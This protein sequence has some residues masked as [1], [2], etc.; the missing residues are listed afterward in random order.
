M[1]PYTKQIVELHKIHKAIE[2]CGCNK[3][4]QGGGDDN[5][6][7]DLI[8]F[9]ELFSGYVITP[10]EF[11]SGSYLQ[12]YKSIRDRLNQYNETYGF[13]DRL[14]DGVYIMPYDRNFEGNNEIIN[15]SVLPF[16]IMGMPDEGSLYLYFYIASE[17]SV[18]KLLNTPP[19]DTDEFKNLRRNVFD[20]HGVGTLSREY[21]SESYACGGILSY[22]SLSYNDNTENLYINTTVISLFNIF[23][24]GRYDDE[25]HKILFT[26]NGE[27][28]FIFFDLPDNIATV[29]NC[30]KLCTAMNELANIY[31]E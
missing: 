12:K 20:S 21:D 19:E 17:K 18:E 3:D 11:E 7:L 4:E 2:N 8:K 9:G 30:D 31:G 29:D 26:N 28:T 5:E 22:E 24:P 23:K 13:E 15:Y 27:D 14:V 10:E 25:N 6:E 16:E 1:T